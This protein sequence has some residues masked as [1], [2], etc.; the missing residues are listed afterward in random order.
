MEV[1]K[2]KNLTNIIGNGMVYNKATQEFNNNDENV[3][4]DFLLQMRSVM[5]SKEI[6]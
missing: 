6:M 2:D 5:Y 3:D 4:G 1:L